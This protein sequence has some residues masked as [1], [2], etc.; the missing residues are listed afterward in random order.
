[1]QNWKTISMEIKKMGFR[2][3][4]EREEIKVEEGVNLIGGIRTETGIGESCR[5]AANGFSAA[6]IPFG[7]INFIMNKQTK[8]QDRSWIKKET[9][10]PSYN[11]NIF[12]VNASHIPLA[13]QHFG[14]SLFMD[15]Y[16]IGYWAWELQEFPDKWLDSFDLVDEVW[17]PSTFVKEAIE[18]KSPV[19][20][21]TI[22]HSIEVPLFNRITRSYFSIP[23]GRFLFFSMYD[24][25]SLQER[26]NPQAVIAAFKKAFNRNDPSVGLVIKI[27]NSYKN[28]KE[29]DLLKKEVIGYRNIFL[30]NKVLNRIE[31]NGLLNSVDCFV[32]LHRS[33]GFGLG[34]AEAMY[35]GK[36]VIATG[37][38]GNLE[39]MSEENSLL[40]DYEMTKIGENVGPYTHDQM[41]AEPD[42]DTAAQ[43][44][45][46]I[47]K[48]R[49]K[50]EQIGIAGK[51][52]IHTQ[53]S[54]SVIGALAKNRL[55]FL[56]LLTD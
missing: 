8:N 24:V 36:P 6:N 38:S 7:I 50:A 23:R 5:I 15:R 45:K 9:T 25:L 17:V 31:I 2:I 34:L 16:N 40:V 14:D 35:L 52:T 1:M 30:I 54:P 18:K 21:I 4:K 42:V 37:W 48:D 56:G 44:M 46:E 22:P 32:S 49:N 41:W 10:I 28:L 33:E 39:F 12:H 55:E 13:Y 20:V 29:V 3:N 11:T 19:P 43:H 26:K 47:C 51:K 53:F 27:N